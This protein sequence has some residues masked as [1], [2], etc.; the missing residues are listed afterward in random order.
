MKVVNKSQ[1]TQFQSPWSVRER[2][3]MIIWEWVWALCC[4]WTPKPFNPWRLWVLRVFG[5][6]LEGVPFVHQRARI[7]IPWNLC[8]KHRACLGDRANAY[9]LGVVE[10]EEAA[11]IAQ[12]AYLC[13]GTHEFE[14]SAMPLA[15]GTIRVQ[16][17]AFVGARA[18][19]LPGVTI[20]TRAVVGAQSVVTKDVPEYTVVAGNPARVIR[21]L[22]KAEKL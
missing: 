5:A 4:S 20:G 18:I 1:K 12:E 8:M 17:N 15:V 13:T 22:D 10:I 9:T 11:T 2:A 19:V 3:L 6:N 14:D 21:E 16:P 7:Q